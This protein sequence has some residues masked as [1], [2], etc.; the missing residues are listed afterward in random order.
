MAEERREEHRWLER[1]V[2]E[3]TYEM[4]AD[5]PDG[6]PVKDTGTE[7]VRSLEGVWI[8]CEGRGQMTDGAPAVT[9]M[10]LGFDPAKGRF[11]GTYIGSMMT[12]L[13][14]Y[15]G[16][17]DAATNVLALDSEGPS[18]VTEG[19]I[20]KYRDTIELKSDD[21]RVMTSTYQGADGSWTPFM[22]TH[23]RRVK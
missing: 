8:V 11:V 16:E 5:G 21:H 9:L 18:F 3:W 17:L 19:E 13:W 20:A 23:Y 1:L 4:E 7:S 14:I 10:T 22:T 2:G 12:S 6:E 15:E